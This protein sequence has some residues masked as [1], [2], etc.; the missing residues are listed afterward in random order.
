VNSRVLQVVLSLTPGGTERLVI[1]LSKRLHSD[2]G[3]AVCC[4]DEPG[5]WASELTECGITVKALGRTPGFKPDLGR[6]LAAMAAREGAD[7]LHCHHYSPFV[8]GAIASLWQPLRVIFTEHG[9]VHDGP[10]SR[11]RRFVN[12]LLR[13][14]PAGVYAVSND[15]K[16]YMTSEGFPAEQVHVIHNG[17]DTGPG[18]TDSHRVL[19]R[20]TLGLPADRIVVG[21]VGRLDPVK[22]LGTLLEAF[23]CVVPSFPTAHLVLVGDGEERAR[24]ERLIASYGLSSRVALTGYRRDARALLRG[25]D[26]Y[27]NSSVFEGVSLTILE[28]MAAGLPVVAT[29]V[30]GTPEVIRADT[31]GMLVPRR[32]A[33]ALAG[34]LQA[35]LGDSNMRRAFGA[36]GRARV[37]NHF[38][39]GR[40][41]D[42]YAAVY[43]DREVRACVA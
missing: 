32:N 28:A 19:A 17:I 18:T 26:V 9:R 37:E 1:E 22:D 24:L 14:V 27:V 38:S 42:D 41:V 31:T 12:R 8:Y 36:A 39:L 10:P 4:L 7:T 15:L 16:R 11:K 29:H 5:A 21:A 23:A 30:G 2:H 25:F 40:M 3:M 13:R 43:G 6:R 35:L 20:A 33:S 34:A